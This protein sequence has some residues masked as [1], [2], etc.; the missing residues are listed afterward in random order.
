MGS[1]E[2]EA[3]GGGHGDVV[4]CVSGLIVRVGGM[5]RRRGEGQRFG[6]FLVSARCLSHEV[7]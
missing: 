6:E 2:G 1:W 3:G 5:L 7:T 4:V